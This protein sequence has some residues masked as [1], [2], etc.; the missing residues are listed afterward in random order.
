MAPSPGEQ[1]AYLG[2]LTS[3][4]SGSEKGGTGKAR[5][6]HLQKVVNRIAEIK[7]GGGGSQLGV[8]EGP[9]GPHR[10]HLAGRRQ[11]VELH[12]HRVSDIA[13]NTLLKSETS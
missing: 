3:S 8:G 12:N 4:N 13:E 11:K 1:R 2:R 9:H 10:Q 7:K 5:F 6:R